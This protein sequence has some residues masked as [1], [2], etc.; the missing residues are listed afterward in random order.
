MTRVPGTSDKDVRRT[1]FDLFS[2]DDEDDEDDDDDDEDDDD[3]DP[4]PSLYV[5]EL[6]LV[7]LLRL[8][9]LTPTYTVGGIYV[10]LELEAYTVRSE[11]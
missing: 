9:E 2:D 4:P 11:N 8:G 10:R 5:D 6:I 3:E 1:R 7:C